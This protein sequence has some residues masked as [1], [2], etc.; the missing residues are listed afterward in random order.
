M[1]APAPGAV[2][3]RTGVAV[4]CINVVQIYTTAG[5]HDVVALRGVN[6][7]IRPG[8]AVALL[9]PSGSGKSTLLSLFGGV[10]RPSAGKILVDGQDISRI[11]ESELGRL[12]S[13]KVASLLQ[14]AGR[15]LLSYATPEEN[16]EFARKALD[17]ASRRRLPSPHELLDRLGMAELAGRPMSSMSGGERQRVAFA[18]AVSSGAGLLL[19]DEPTSQ[20]SHDDRDVMIELIH[21]V[22]REFGT[23]VVL[24]T[25]D[26]EIAAQMPRSITIRNGRIGSEGRHGFDFGVVDEDGAVHIPDEL[27]DRFPAGTLVQFE[28]T[29]GGV[30]LRPVDES[31]S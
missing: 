10:L 7:D 28:Q 26:P 21:R 23:T 18:A 29:E 8:D 22:N 20:L 25:H 12:R 17:V 11:R 27:A 9:G 3:R 31:G 14:G 1:N 24:V 5:G 15:N 2:D 6:L 19:A 16:V 13:G 30:L 4:R